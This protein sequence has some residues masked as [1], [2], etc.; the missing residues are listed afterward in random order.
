MAN[1]VE[2]KITASTNKLSEG[3]KESEKIVDKSAKNIEETG[4]KLF[5]HLTQQV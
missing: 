5:S 1:E 2:V 3:M 4:K